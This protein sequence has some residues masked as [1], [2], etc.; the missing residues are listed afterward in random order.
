MQSMEKIKE[1]KEDQIQLRTE[2]KES[3]Q[4]L[5]ELFKTL[6]LLFK[7]YN[8]PSPSQPSDDPEMLFQPKLIEP[9]AK[10]KANHN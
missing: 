2:L 5:N 4:G 7:H 8:I 1:L 9:I 3:N 6:S 10:T